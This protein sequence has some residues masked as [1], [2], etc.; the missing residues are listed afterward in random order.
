[1]LDKKRIA[2]VALS[3]INLGNARPLEHRKGTEENKD[4]R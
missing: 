2:L 1:M 3:G 4:I